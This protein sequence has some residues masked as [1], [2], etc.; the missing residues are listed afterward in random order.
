MVFASKTVV[1]DFR[2]GGELDATRYD[3][4]T[5][6]CGMVFRV[7]GRAM[8]DV[9]VPVHATPVSLLPLSLTSVSSII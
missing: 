9:E 3:R 5:P 7:S 2:Q 4:F 8:L 1:R 6:L